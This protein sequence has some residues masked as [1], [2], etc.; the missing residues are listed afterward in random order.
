[1]DNDFLQTQNGD[2]I[3]SGMQQLEL[4]Q[5]EGITQGLEI[6]HGLDL[7]QGVH[8]RVRSRDV[9]NLS[10]VRRRQGTYWICTIP[11]ELWE[12]KLEEG[13]QYV[14]GQLE[15]GEEQAYEHWQVM[16]ILERKGSLTRLKSL[17]GFSGFHAELTRSKAAEDYVWKEDTR[18]EGTQFEFGSKKLRRNSEQDWEG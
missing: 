5:H 10:N 4:E 11:R 17:F 2:R 3:V 15:I 8:G 1:M 7:L 13:F 6:R 12:P 14:K 9:G 18:V 16:V